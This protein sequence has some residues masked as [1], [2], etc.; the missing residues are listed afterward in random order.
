MC[1]WLLKGHWKWRGWTKD[2]VRPQEPQA[3]VEEWV[4]EGV[5]G[6]TQKLGGET[7]ELCT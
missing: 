5:S 4:E 3:E 1:S 6:K 2:G 7:C